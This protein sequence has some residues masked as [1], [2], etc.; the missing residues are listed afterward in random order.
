MTRAIEPPNSV[1]LLVSREEFTP[2]ASFGSETAVATI[3]CVA[4]G[5]L[6]AEVGPTS[7]ALAPVV[8]SSG[9]IQ[10][11][12]FVLQTEGHVSV[13]DV[14][15]REYETIGVEPGWC[16]VI[17]WGNRYDEPSDVVFEVREIVD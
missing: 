10:L 2:P 4:V 6:S 7:V 8:E 14:Y 15:N 13:R 17:V 5:V 1:I 11:G 12:E 16:S 3:D 9:R